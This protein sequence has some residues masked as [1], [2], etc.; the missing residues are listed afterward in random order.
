MPDC[1]FCSI[2]SGDIP[3]RIVFQDEDLVVFH[4]MNPQAPVHVLVIPK[5]HIAT[6]SDVTDEDAPLMGQIWAK[7]PKIA[8]DLGVAGDGFRIV[9]N[10]RKAAGQ[11]V[12]HIH[13]HLLGGRAMGWPP[14]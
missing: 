7:I 11:V 13:F 2:A 4:D 14:G 9:A 1:I 3:A 6:L 8:A 5:K 12:L 10:C